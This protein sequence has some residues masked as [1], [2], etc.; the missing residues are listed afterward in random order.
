MAVPLPSQVSLPIA[1]S[2]WSGGAALN[3]VITEAAVQSRVAFQAQ[4]SLDRRLFITAFGHRP[5]AVRVGGLAFAAGCG[6]GPPG[7]DAV[8][9]FYAR[10]NVA[11]TGAPVMVTIGGSGATTSPAF[12]V[13]SDLSVS[14]PADMLGQF[15][16]E[17]ITP[18]PT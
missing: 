7:I 11:A 14:R 2:G 1:I 4:P 6:G 16:F 8:A 17:F 5:T 12:L 18:P 9:A 15:G 3:A 10:N 13:G